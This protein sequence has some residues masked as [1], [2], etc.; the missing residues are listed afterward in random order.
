MMMPD[1][2]AAALESL[3]LAVVLRGSTWAYPLIN[4]GHILG[5]ALLVGGIVPLDLRLLGGWPTVPLAPLWRV[6]VST[7]GAGLGLAAICGSLLFITRATTYV[8]SSLFAAKMAFVGIGLANALILHR[9]ARSKPIPAQLSW[10]SRLQAALSL[11][12]W[13]MVL[14]LGRLVGYF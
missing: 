2:W 5:V 13:L 11:F 10:S 6:L 3:P 14:T 4:A 12:V 9:S 7:A 1:A 8:N